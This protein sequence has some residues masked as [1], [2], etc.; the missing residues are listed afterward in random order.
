MY[1]KFADRIPFLGRNNPGSYVVVPD[2]SFSY[3]EF[4]RMAQEK[5]FLIY[6]EIRFRGS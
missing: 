2:D 3:R 1:S 6:D 4:K 5:E